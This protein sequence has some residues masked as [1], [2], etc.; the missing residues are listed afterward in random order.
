MHDTTRQNLEARIAKYGTKHF[1]KCLIIER[2]AAIIERGL[3]HTFFK[4][5]IIPRSM[6]AKPLVMPPLVSYANVRDLVLN[7]PTLKVIHEPANW[8]IPEG[9]RIN[10]FAVPTETLDFPTI[11]TPS[12]KH[13]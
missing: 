13:K 2:S 9:E 4:L 3:A 6:L 5:H 12:R 1:E 8:G 11:E 7:T 10:F